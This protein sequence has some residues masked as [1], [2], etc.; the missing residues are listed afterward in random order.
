MPLKFE[1][2]FMSDKIYDELTSIL[3]KSYE[4]ACILYIDRVINPELQARFDAYKAKHSITD[5]RLFHG[6]STNSVKSICNDGYKAALNKRSAYGHGTY[7]SSKASYSKDYTDKTESDE[8]FM[9]VNKVCLGP[10]HNTNG[11]EIFVVADDDA[12]FPEYV[13]CFHK[14]AKN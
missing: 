7:F 11:S 5:T 1:P 13:I 6:T 8:S 10:G 4:N 12:A 9:L 2:V 14:E 3:R